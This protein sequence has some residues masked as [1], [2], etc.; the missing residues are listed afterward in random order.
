MRASAMRMFNPAAPL[1]P[2]GSIF[3]GIFGG[4]RAEGGPGMAG[5]AYVTGEKRREIFVPQEDGTFY[6]ERPGTA[7]SGGNTTINNFHFS[8]GM[9]PADMAFIQSQI[10]MASR[11]TQSETIGTIRDG[12]QTDSGFLG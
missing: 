1:G 9:T 12:H 8:P 10:A 2:L 11:A 6:T 5:R 3:Q 7:R 4:H